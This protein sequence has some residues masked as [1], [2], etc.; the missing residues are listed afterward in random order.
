VGQVEKYIMLQFGYNTNGFNCHTLESALEI[1]AG[2]GYRGVAITLDNYILN[3]RDADL[4]RKLALTQAMLTKHSLAC[5]IETGARFLLDP[6]HKHEPTLISA[7]AAARQIRL[8]FLKRA[9]KIAAR[10][11]A[12]ALSFWS[13]ARH[14]PVTETE[15]WQWLV[16]GCR[17]LLDE[18]ARY[19][20]P[21]AF[22]PEPGMFIENLTQYQRLKQRLDHH[23]WGLTLDLGHAFLTEAAGP[24]VCIRQFKDDIKNIHAEDMRQGTHEHL[25]FGEGEMD[26][27]EIFK[28]LKDIKY[29]GLIN[30]ELSRHSRNAVKAASQA[31]GFLYRFLE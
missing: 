28:A 23:L 3:P 8:D 18:A 25:Q 29:T 9:L 13:G 1:I 7:D 21:L 15:A 6:R 27:I 10:L 22:E 31:Y 14:D 19:G 5:V 17:E 4:D 20:V 12:Q 24:A 11:E 26:F 16:A 2:L 30:V